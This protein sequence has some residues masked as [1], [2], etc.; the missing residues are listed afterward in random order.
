[1]PSQE[2][3]NHDAASI[4]NSVVSSVRKSSCAGRAYAGSRQRS[5]G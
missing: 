3:E 5:G 4:F 2:P 1:M